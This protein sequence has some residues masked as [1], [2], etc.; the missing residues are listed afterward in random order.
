MRILAILLLLISL[1][2]AAHPPI[3]TAR[4]TPLRKT[5]IVLE[6]PKN[7]ARR[8]LGYDRL[9]GEAV[10]Y[11]PKPSVVRV[12]EESGKYAFK[13]IGYDGTEKTVIYQRPDA[14]NAVVSARI[15]TK[16]SRSNTFTYV[17]ENLRSSGEE[18]TSFFIQTFASHVKP[19][20][21]ADVYVGEVSRN[22]KEFKDGYWLGYGVLNSSV[23][24][25]RSKQ[26]KLE[27]P[28]PPGL[29][30]C[31]VAGGARGMKGVG[32]DMP[33]E[34]ENVL[35]G[36]EIWPYGYTIGPVD[37][38]KSLSLK[39]R[40]KY[41]RKRLPVFESLGWITADSVSWY[42][43]HLRVHQIAQVFEQAAGDLKV[44]KV[45]TEVFAMIQSIN[46]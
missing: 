17:V 29:V 31:R 10:Y 9:T 40:I 12:D 37:K 27:S 39:K 14:I 23:V 7:Y 24:A 35:P 41:I 16:G 45:T 42:Q 2:G 22:H 18:L 43:Q 6:S 19:T 4:R 3:Q 1:A 32:E 26:F 30:E 25:G 46:Q 28:A 20:R 15:S 36:Y 11:D 38:L 5:A 34:L 44:D 13:W 21:G 33:Q 8:V